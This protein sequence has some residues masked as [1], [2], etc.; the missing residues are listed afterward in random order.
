MYTMYV[1][2]QRIFFLVWQHLNRLDLVRSLEENSSSLC[3][4][5]FTGHFPSLRQFDHLHDDHEGARRRTTCR[6]SPCT[7]ASPGAASPSVSGP[8]HHLGYIDNAKACLE[9]FFAHLGLK[10][11]L[12]KESISGLVERSRWLAGC[13]GQ[14]R[15]A[16]K[17]RKNS[18]GEIG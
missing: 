9:F 1:N 6:R 15:P 13:N 11:L 5:T 7:S 8:S 18:G 16:K 3:F 17:N 2:V 14:Y 12:A 4:V 10:S